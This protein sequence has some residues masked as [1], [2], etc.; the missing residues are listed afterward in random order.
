MKLL[1]IGSSIDRPYSSQ[2]TRLF[3]SHVID[4][5]FED[6]YT[7]VTAIANKARSYAGVLTS[8]PKLVG[9]FANTELALA[10]LV[11]DVEEDTNTIYEEEVVV[12]KGKSIED[13]QGSYFKLQ[14]DK[15]LVVIP[16]LKHLFTVPYA[17]FTT[18]KF[19]A[20]ITNPEIWIPTPEFRW[21][22]VRTWKDFELMQA[23]LDSSS[24]IAT[25]IETKS[26]HTINMVGFCGAKVVKGDW[27]LTSYV[28]ELKDSE[29]LSGWDARNYVKAICENS[30]PKIFHNGIYD[31]TW[32]LH[33]GI[34][35]RAWYWDTLGL[36]HSLYCELPRSLAFTS[37]MFIRES[38]FWKDMAGTDEH[39]YN[40][41]DTYNTMLAFLGIMKDF[42]DWAKTNY[43]MT[44]PLIAPSMMCGIEGVKIDSEKRK[45]LLT[46][47]KTKLE[48][49]LT[50]LQGV[51]GNDKFNP[52]SPVHTKNLLA[53]LGHRPKSADKKEI[54]KIL[55]KDA[56]A[57]LLVER[58]INYR[59]A[60]KLL[61]SYLEVQDYKGRYTY[62][63]NP[64]GTESGRFSS[65]KSHLYSHNKGSKFF[66]YGQ[67]VQNTP[68]YI[69]K[70]LRA[71][72]G[73]LI[74]ELDKSASESWC[75]ALISRDPKLWEVLC[76]TTDFHKSNA[77]LFFGVP[78]EEVT[79]DLRQLAKPVNHGAN[80][81]MGAATLV[82][83]ITVKN[84]LKAKTLCLAAWEGRED[85][86][87]LR[88]RLL[89][90]KTP[91]AIAEFLLSR[92]HA[93]YKRL[94]AVWYKEIQAEVA[95]TG[96]LVNPS[97]FTRL[98]F[99]D[100]VKN[101][102]DLNA[103]IAH[104]PQHF[105]V[106]LV[107]RSFR[108]IWDELQDGVNFR[109]KAQIHDSIVFQVK[110]GCEHLATRANEL[111]LVEVE[112]YGKKCTIPN[113]DI[114]LTTFWNEG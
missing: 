59:K 26:Y 86:A 18:K 95:R 23:D 48:K 41:R 30:V 114:E 69:K 60:R 90:C 72:E 28:V 6:N 94:Q 57:G 42:P 25:D 55:E 21:I 46:E 2:L 5:L 37:A 67:Q 56:F 43:K 101:K 83:T 8:S 19:V 106:S 50:E 73:Y 40:A 111:M 97:G 109:M 13:Y 62:S 79:K 4:M 31:N 66:R 107:N 27:V 32:L 87:N 52:S 65:S 75:T 22:T 96:R 92:F 44:F 112:V 98:C 20:K 91:V 76:T 68:S 89:L 78:F 80:Y 64:F 104:N 12:R 34:A 39:E 81:N 7:S 61:S 99:G 24:L 45:Q 58:L 63:L 33:Y 105:S 85:M 16:P 70:M 108:K 47:Q 51:L 10:D 71:D 49:N 74:C 93:T 14:G 77:N 36:M 17:K 84:V 9:L 1:Y 11:E 53:I 29:E 110:L 103:Y 54:N 100:P 3:P 82:E 88:N 113:G 38:I 102:S 35:T 15:A